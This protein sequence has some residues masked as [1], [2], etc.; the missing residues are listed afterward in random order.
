MC[1]RRDTGY[2]LIIVTI[3]FCIV[4]LRK[5]IENKYNVSNLKGINYCPQNVG[6]QMQTK[7]RKTLDSKTRSRAGTEWVV[8]TPLLIN[9]HKSFINET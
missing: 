8:V 3:P 9:N 6:V 2:N 5:F 4:A 7:P 1:Y